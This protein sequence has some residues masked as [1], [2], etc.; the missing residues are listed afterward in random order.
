MTANGFR[1]ERTI[2]RLTFE[3]STGLEGLVVRIK[4]CT[5]KEFNRIM[6]LGQQNTTE[7]E[8]EVNDLFVS[9]LVEWNLL[10]DDDHPVPLTQEGLDT[11]EPSLMAA[12]ILAWHSAMTEVKAPLRSDSGNGRRLEEAE[13]GLGKSSASL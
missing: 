1:P 10:D 11:Q 5:I 13:L 4:S 12:I 6:W 3:N 9:K 8:Q 7:S 2:Y